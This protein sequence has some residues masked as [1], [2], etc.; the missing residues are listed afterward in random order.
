MLVLSRKLN[1]RI[2]FPSIN[3]A[4]QVVSVKPGVVRLGIDAP[5]EVTVLREEVADRAGAAGQPAKSP[6]RELNHLVRNRLNTANVGVAL[7][8]RQLQLG[9]VE[10]CEATLEKV[11][12]ELKALQ[13][14][15]EEAAHQDAVPPPP[16]A[17]RRKALLVEDDKNECELLAGFLRLAGLD[18]TAVNDGADAL[19]YLG[20]Q[21]RP[22][23]V[24]LDMLMPRVDGPTTVR[25]IRR[26]P[27]L[28]G[29]KV[30]GVSGMAREQ[31]GL[32][33][34]GAGVDGWFRKPFDPEAM[35]QELKRDFAGV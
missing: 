5:P 31:V 17:A 1:E 24:L 23:V 11:E 8:R 15:V 32:E 10:S 6:L 14:K 26:N 16:R 28:A 13:Q 25:A 18:V 20:N 22:D 29:L 7:L 33:S 3:A 34:G 9:M 27:R 2:V 30:Y 19:D 4:V 12:A 21:D 35:L